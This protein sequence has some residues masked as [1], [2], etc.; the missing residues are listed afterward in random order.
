MT[1]PNF[2]APEKTS[3][4]DQEV[5]ILQYWQDQKIF[6]KTIS[7][8]NEQNDFR[9]F[10]GPP[11][12]TGSP[13][14]GHI[15]AGAIKDAIPRY[16]TMCGYR[17][18]R[19]WGWDCHGV[20]VEFLIE[21]EHKIGGKPGIEKMGIGKFN[22]LCRDAVMRCADEW[23][24]TVARMG[25][26]VDFKNDYKTMD[27]EFMESV[28]WVFKT[29]W[30]KGLIYE[31]EKVVP[32][33]PK[34]GS[35]LS[36]F[37]A[38][39]NYKDIDDPAVTV[40]FELKNKPPVKNKT[41]VSQKFVKN[42]ANLM[43]GV[44][45]NN[46][47]KPG[48]IYKVG[49][50]PEAV[51]EKLKIENGRSVYL[52]EF[53]YAKIRDWVG[54]KKGHPELNPSDLYLLPYLIANPTKVLEDKKHHHRYLLIESDKHK[55]VIVLE[56]R[57]QKTQ[58]VSFFYEIRS[59]K[60]QTVLY[61][62]SLGGRAMIPPYTLPNLR[63]DLNRLAARFPSRQASITSE[64]IK[65]IDESQ[66]F[67][68]DEL[69]E[70]S[71]T[72]NT[73]K[74]Y[75]LAWTTTPWTM[76]N[77][78]ALC[79]NPDLAYSFVRGE[80]GVYIVGSKL[81]TKFFGEDAEVTKTIKGSELLNQEYVP[82]FPFLEN[83]RR[84][85]AF[86]VF[87]DNF[88]GELEG[89]GIVHISPT[90]EDD[91]R[92][93]LREGI[94]LTYPFDENGYFDFSLI[95]TAES[96]EGLDG[97]YFREDAEV[98]GSKEENGNNWVLENLGDK[99]FKREQIRHS[100]P[101]CWRTD[102]A[103]M[104]RGI[105]T[106]F[107]NVE[108]IKSTMIAKNK[109]INWLPAYLRDG[110]FGKILEGAP[111]WAIS[112]NRY[113][114]A[115]IPVWR[116]EKCE[117]IEVM[118]SQADLEAKTGKKVPDLHKHFIDDLVWDCPK[119]EAKMVRIPE[120]LDC[121]FESGSMPYASVHYPFNQRIKS[122]I[123][124]KTPQ[125]D[126]EWNTYHEIAKKEVLEFYHPELT[127]DPN[128]EDQSREGAIKKIFI[129]HDKIIG[130]AFLFPKNKKRIF[131]GLLGI[132]KGFQRQGLGHKCLK[133]LETFL[134]DIGYEELVFNANEKVL[135]FYDKNGYQKNFWKPDTTNFAD[136]IPYGKKL[137][138][139]D[140]TLTEQI[141]NIANILSGVT[142]ENFYKKST[143]RIIGILPISV[144]KELKIHKDIYLSDKLYGKIRGWWDNQPGHPEMLESDFY[145]LPALLSHPAMVLVDQKS[146]DR[147]IILNNDQ[148]SFLV[149]L[150]DS[151]GYTEVLS[152]FC[153]RKVGEKNEYLNNEKRYKKVTLEGLPSPSCIS[154][155]LREE[156]RRLV[157]R[158]P[159]RQGQLCDDIIKFFKER[160]IIN[161][162]ATLLPPKLPVDLS[163]FQP[164]DFIAEGL[165]QTRGWF[166]TL[167]VLGC[168]LFE[169]NIYKNVITNGI[170]LAE[171]GQKMS[172]SKK[173]YPDPNL[174][175]DKYGADSMR[176]YLLSSP[177]VRAE[178]FRFA[179]RGVA[180]ILKTIL[181]P[182]KSTYQFFST[183]ANI[184]NWSP[185]KITFIRHGEG[186]HNVEGVYSGEID[187][188]HDLTKK[189]IADIEKLKETLPTFDK[190]YS[191]PFL[192]T[193][194]TADILFGAKN[195]QIDDRLVEINFGN[196]EGKSY[197]PVLER[198]KDK[199]GE[200]L[201]DIQARMADFITEIS[202]E[203]S[204]RNI[205]VISHG[206]P[207]RY[208][209]GYFDGYDTDEKILNYE[210]VRPGEC[211][212][213]I[214]PP[215]PKTELD[216]W[217]ISEL[218][219]L[220]KN[221]RQKMD[222]Y[223]IDEALNDIPAFID[224]LNNWFL[225]RSRK[226]FWANGMTEEKISGYE[227]LHYVL[228]TLAKILAPITPFFAEKLHRDLTGQGTE[229]SVHLKYMPYADEKRI[230]TVSSQKIAIIREVVSLAAGIRARKKIKLR[231][232]L[233]SLSLIVKT[234]K[235][236][237]LTDDDLAII[238]EEANVKT[239][240]ILEESAVKKFAKKIV[241]VDARQVGRKFGK[242]VQSL[243][244]AGKNG[245]FI[246]RDN[247]KI[248]IADEILTAEEYTFA[249]LTED[250]IDAD[251]TA[252]TVVL[253]QTEISEA[254]RIEGIAREIIRAIQ[255]KRKSTG[256]EIADRIKIMYATES[257][258]I[259]KVFTQFGSMIKREVLAEEISKA[260]TTDTNNDI[261]ID[262]ETLSLSLDKA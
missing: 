126:D 221:Y 217:I 212:V 173:N 62:K 53:V 99:L 256:F 220:L 97:K 81:V 88:V 174:I 241:K 36:N 45:A 130:M 30:D 179:E 230:D 193:K 128:H 189:G 163:D 28:W 63:K 100:Y 6:E 161:T 238:A 254:L 216:K 231:Q 96:P 228:H 243:I 83:K 142:P 175:F 260:T 224:N 60:N 194:H 253:L 103:L 131:M 50:L 205:A 77:H 10:D 204:N 209:R 119:C 102:C 56:S 43:D 2:P 49:A 200:S 129:Q 153:I 39:L 150:D 115:P 147:V 170:I 114:G 42:I 19:K 259:E 232:P 79:V 242:K 249:Y 116:C 4:N 40:K 98:E 223:K 33:S 138:T 20:P 112:R 101:H 190:V 208:A 94:S 86:R 21:K 146:H 211:A 52:S 135:D 226:R 90:G 178:N 156:L 255:E 87:G 108:K 197:R 206:G 64:I 199:S 261:K 148:H 134:Q 92:I 61:E 185:Q 139:I 141:R 132:K 158:F 136:T 73:S 44:T 66:Y 246:L 55:F 29:L 32:Y 143:K 14:Y 196:L 107:V 154:E 169:K 219:I 244:V 201:Q 57:S 229:N 84:E 168:A 3:I 27:P 11:F 127:Y 95:E 181:L 22:E 80:D 155:T 8:R 188:P 58:I 215:D 24:D 91:A 237:A 46:Y 248:K 227:T 233:G 184:D 165:D 7:S 177:V 111:D 118:G 149:V 35:P 222:E 192:R 213:F 71:A 258:D 257:T 41:T 167:H 203:K 34:L 23:E 166:Y 164:A 110:R 187:N 37:E 250:G 25:R 72:E 59:R 48:K 78:L 225:R 157:G 47:Q 15:L 160:Q 31:G 76:P 51:V 18:D 202:T 106:W 85:G 89:T 207:I 162:T 171:D 262:T 182:L 125:T 247:G 38:N 191:S 176:F 17:V 236:L 120:V 67:I 70:Q 16:K 151:K 172:K 145:F 54:H 105:K 68:E 117:N 122:D 235:N 198:L 183:Y 186:S 210:I 113:W 69:C 124:I 234:D 65:M 121:W 159:S 144:A 104:Y 93:L 26:F 12:A 251:S 152:F 137:A 109:D 74:T 9:F 245:N 5:E 252:R 75:F 218:Q 140:T 123:E 180:D 195:Y 133:Q 239:V 214:L 240:K 13:H 82:P 1:K